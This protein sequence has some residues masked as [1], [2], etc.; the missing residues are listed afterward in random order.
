MVRRIEIFPE[1]ALPSAAEI[2]A[3]GKARARD[4]QV[5]PGRFLTHYGVPSEAEYKRRRMAEGVVMQHAQIGYRDKSKSRRAWF[6]VWDAVEK[7]GARVDRYG[8]CLDWSMGYPKAQRGKLGR[9]TGMILDDIDDFVALTSEAPVAPHFGDFVIGMPS[10]VENTI[11]ALAAGATSVGNLGQYF[12]FRLPE[13]H[14]DVATTVATVEA[15]ALMAAQ[16][17]EVL[18]HSNLD[19]GFAPLFTDLSCTFGAALIERY[20]IEELIGG[21]LSHCFGN[22]FTD[23]A[24]RLAFQRAL[25]RGR[26]QVPGTMIYG[27]TVVYEADKISNYG[28]LSA[29]LLADALGQRLMPSGHAIN[30]VPITEGVRIPDI[31]EVIDVQ[32]VCAKLVE[33][34]ELWLPMV[35]L[36]GTDRIADAIVEG[37]ERFKTRVL[38]GLRRSGIQVDD[39]FELLLAMRRI[40]PKKLEELYGPGTE[41]R[42]TPRGRR[43]HVPSTTMTALA[44]AA[45]KKIKALDAPMRQDISGA[46]LKAVVACTDVHEYGKILIEEILRGLG[47]GIID[48]GVHADPENLLRKAR[49]NGADVIALSTYN[50]V[51]LDYVEQLKA[52]MAGAKLQ[53]PVFIGGRLNQ[54]PQNSN[55]SLPVDVSK[56]IAAAGM[57]PCLTPE[58]LV[59]PLARMARDRRK[60]AP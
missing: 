38:D 13:W 60:A 41:D 1:S 52:A 18:I 33:Q 39:A 58:D 22:T 44:R 34:S 55:T 57:T 7:A 36:P 25:A 14:D 15:L 54:V 16:P 20:V 21:R 27:N 51:A 3:R 46:G 47:V 2:I 29:Y 10:A 59:I 23:P 43:P 12:T 37:G 56:D 35:D 5:R 42:G 49:E 31:D 17:V 26:A 6:E 40:G 19:D 50:G 4:A 28:G 30:A 11:A 45:E 9:G 48:A 32:L 24:T 8:I 53:L